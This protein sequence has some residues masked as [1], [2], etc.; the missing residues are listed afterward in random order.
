MTHTVLFASIGEDLANTGKTIAHTFGLDWP[1]FIAQ[2]ISFCLVTFLLYKFAYH[3]ILK[4]L[5]ERRQRIADGLEN[6]DK[7]KA[8]LAATE[9]KSRKILTDAN[10]TATKFIEEARA[11][12]AKTLEVET[13]KAIAAAND[14]IAKARQAN[15]AELVRMKTELRK[16]VGRLVV[17]T[18]AKVTGNILT[19]DQQNRL[20]EETTKQLASN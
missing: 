7:I 2:V 12:A 15:E 13:Q 19:P 5:E 14:I 8:E 6:A 16:E 20:A 10:A 4:M 1:H 18:T 3:P 9:E 17:A 11:S